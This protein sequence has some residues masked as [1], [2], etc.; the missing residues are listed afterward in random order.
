MRLLLEKISYMSGRDFSFAMTN[1]FLPM[2][3]LFDLSLL[4]I[5]R[6]WPNI[7]R[8]IKALS[9]FLYYL[10]MIKRSLRRMNILGYK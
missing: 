8:N 5:L 1:I 9:S 10:I 7:S 2:V 3:V 6:Y 4:A